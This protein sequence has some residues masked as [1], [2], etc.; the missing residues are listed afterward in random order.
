M[1]LLPTRTHIQNSRK[2]TSTPAEFRW[3]HLPYGIDRAANQDSNFSFLWTHDSNFKGL[4]VSSISISRSLLTV[5]KNLDITITH[6]MS[7]WRSWFYL[8]YPG[9]SIPRSWPGHKTDFIIIS[10]CKQAQSP[11]SDLFGPKPVC[12]LAQRLPVVL[13]GMLRLCW[14]PLPKVGHWFVWR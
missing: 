3:H 14:F 10:L 7:S 5:I 6:A 8:S 2:I 1:H 12:S 13:H 4:H 11:L 9:I